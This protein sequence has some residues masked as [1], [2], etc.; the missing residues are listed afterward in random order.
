M[1]VLLKPLSWM[2]YLSC[3]FSVATS[4]TAQESA[5]PKV[6]AFAERVG[7]MT[8][9]EFSG[10]KEWNY[11]LSRD[12]NTLHLVLDTLD[13]QS[14]DLLESLNSLLVS[15]IEVEEKEGNKSLV[16]I[17]LSD[18]RVESFDYLIQQPSKLVLD[19]FVNDN[20]IVEEL[21][22]KSTKPLVAKQETE[23]KPTSKKKLSP[24][25]KPNRSPASEY[26]VI[27]DGQVD[28]YAQDKPMS[29]QPP[30]NL[31]DLF[32]F[33][34]MGATASDTSMEA[35]VVEAQGNIYLRFPLLKLS[36]PHLKELQ[37]YRPQ[38]EIRKS[39]SDENKQA[40]SL[41]ALFNQRS[42]ASFIKAKRVFKKNFPKSSYDEI[43][44]YVEADTWIE[45][46]KLNQ[47]PEYL[48]KAMNIYKMLIERYPSSPIAERTLINTGLLAHDVGE[49]FVA[50]KMLK[51]YVK[52]YSQS[53]FANHVKLYLADSLAELKNYEDATNVLNDV[54]RDGEINTKIEA[55]YRKGD[56][57]FLK[58]SFR[59][60]ERAY[61]EAIA[62]HP[63]SLEKYP[64]A[65][66]NMAEAQFNL[67]EYKKSI[68]SFKKFH[69]VFPN[70]NYGGLALTR[71]G[72]LVDIIYNDR[73]KAQGFYNESYYKYRDTMGG[74]L[75]RMR[76]LSQRFKDM[77][78]NKLEYSK[79]EI[80]RLKKSVDL[81]QVDE[82]AAFMISDGYYYK[83]DYLQS[84]DALISY[85]QVNPQP[86]NIKKFE[87]RISRSI[88]AQVRQDLDGN[89][90]IRALALIEKH[91]K[92]WLSK[93]QRLDIQMYRAEI[94]ETM[95]LL[96]DAERAYQRINKRID[97][98]AGT[99]E[100]AERR[101]VEDYPSKDQVRVRLASVNY[102]SGERKKSVDYLSKV[103]KISALPDNESFDYHY[104][105]SRL[106]Y[107][108]KK[109]DDALKTIKLVSADKVKNKEKANSYNLY[110][111]EL[112]E[113]T[114]DLD[115]ALAILQSFLNDN[116][117]SDDEPL[118]LSRIFGLHRSQGNLELAI[119]TGEELVKKHGSKI[120]TD[121]ERYYLG[122]IYFKNNQLNLA[123][124]TW[125]KL[126]QKSMWAEL[127]RNKAIS[128]E[129]QQKTDKNMSRLPAM[130]K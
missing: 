9:L 39:F 103:K 53:P 21:S 74:A 126:N 118:V 50:T 86:V 110:L 12:D 121:K 99:K 14:R 8:H 80:L 23:P 70:H 27:G 69:E 111:S 16:K 59:R 84:A 109:Y 125:K 128:D 35:S 91:E 116:P 7:S 41:L 92:S 64:N 122:E 47:R 76:S 51:R 98:L 85:F 11:D 101:I 26:M 55:K 88:A 13:S 25:S 106:S 113:R 5:G 115:Q 60:S 56:V 102:K 54:I 31:K 22:S 65:L 72:E 66:F 6:R 104:V 15:K 96:D 119:K 19:I 93:S 117:D 58:Q 83:K 45:L 100:E 79:G 20:K 90:H 105:L 107:D 1:K 127:A 37:S 30:Q 44:T 77:K 43:L 4:A 28:Y 97:N 82:F 3:S 42:F 81:P 120:N 112:Y 49:Y 130:Q 18:K 17:H 32:D 71:V 123:Q 57:F 78:P 67:A 36:N 129:W 89:E 94:Y 40:R 114:G 87:K 34:V 33:G 46:W 24:K 68:D 124:E 62:D 48:T 108:N 95:G 61:Q 52:N 75:A 2:L 38:Y 29:D 63:Q 73:H 10:Q